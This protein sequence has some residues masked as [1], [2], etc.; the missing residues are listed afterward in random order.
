[1]NL[2]QYLGLRPGARSRCPFCDHQRGLAI[3]DRSKYSAFDDDGSGFFKCFACDCAG[4]GVSFLVEARS[5]TRAE[6]S[7]ALGL[8][9]QMA[10]LD[11]DRERQRAA[12]ARLEHRRQNTTMQACRDLAFLRYRMTRRERQDWRFHDTLPHRLRQSRQAQRQAER[13]AGYLKEVQTKT[14]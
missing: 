7:W 4:S 5:M 1:M 9:P 13:V 14:T 2:N 3:W 11:L 12:W 10:L 8:T 6:A